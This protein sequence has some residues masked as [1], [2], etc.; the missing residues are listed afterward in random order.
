[1]MKYFPVFLDAKKLN[2]LVIGG[3]NIA[4]RKIE[5][6]LKTPATI[7]IIAPKANDTVSQLVSEH[8]LNHIK[9]E[10]HA[11]HLER[12]NLVIA[13]TDNEHV[14]QQAAKD[15][16]QRG[17]LLN[18]VD[19]PSLCDYITPAIIDR[20]PMI[21]ALSSEGNAPMLLQ[22]LKNQI[23][24]TLPSHYGVLATFCG[25]HRHRVQ[26]QIPKF[27]QRKLFWQ[28]VIE[29]QVGELLIH[30][31]QEAA[32]SLFEQLLKKS[33]KETLGKLCL[34][35]LSSHDPDLLT[36]K[37]YR[38]MQTADCVF[39]LDNLPTT[40]YDYARKD[41]D[42]YRHWD[43]QHVTTLVHKQQTVVV[44]YQSSIELANNGVGLSL[45]KLSC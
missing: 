17:I 1:M 28:Q 11:I 36:L 7:T 38:A 8:S 12:I 44:L 19:N 34:I 42:K 24:Q 29:G 22:L 21:V 27:A 39:L 18:V 6:L 20:S 16:K 9:Q 5:S 40:F 14:N 31:Q 4:A 10:Y 45:I 13:A 35:K 41:A 3:G 2:T 30:N 43:Q 37:A 33:D 23:D 25:Q 15:A 32:E 26:Q